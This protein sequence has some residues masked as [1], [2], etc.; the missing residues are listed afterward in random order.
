MVAP[1][2]PAD[3]EGRF[4]L[5]AESN[6]QGLFLIASD[7]SYSKLLELKLNL[8]QAAGRWQSTPFSS[9]QTG[10]PD[11]FTSCAERD[12]QTSTRP[13][14]GSSSSRERRREPQIE[15]TATGVRVFVPAQGF[16]GGASLWCL[17]IIIAVFASIF[18]AVNILEVLS[19]NHR[20]W[21]SIILASPFL[22]TG[23]AM[24]V[25][26]WTL[27]QRTALLTV[28]P[29]GLSIDRHSPFRDERNHFSRHI[30][31]EVRVGPSG[32]KVNDTPVMELQV[33]VKGE[34]ALGMLSQCT[35]E[36]CQEIAV[37]LRPGLGLQPGQVV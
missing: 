4:S 10:P 24:M 8:E 18:E 7:Y 26:A 1:S 19:G 23:L 12:C 15:H 21:I 5:H 36:Q 33:W 25:R 13:A 34:K 22:I 11:S 28:D 35:A 31:D 32:M 2:D 29:D 30:I 20:A 17:G 3:Q 16:R 14:T 9:T 6:E 27:G 37:A